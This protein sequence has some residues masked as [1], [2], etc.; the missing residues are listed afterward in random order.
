MSQSFQPTLLHNRS[1]IRATGKDAGKLLQ[2]LLTCNMEHLGKPGDVVYGFLLTPQGRF[3]HEML[4]VKT[5]DG[6][7]LDTYNGNNCAGPK[8][9][10][11]DEQAV[12]SQSGA[13]CARQQSSTEATNNLLKR[14]KIYTLK[15]DAAFTIDTE[16]A[17]LACTQKP[18]DASQHIT[19]T[20]PRHGELGYRIY[21][22]LAALEALT[23][24]SNSTPSY[25]EHRIALGIPLAEDFVP[26]KTL[27]LDYDMDALHG[28]DFEKGCYVGQEV[29]ARMHYR[30]IDKKGIYCIHQAD[31]ELTAHTPITTDDTE[32]G[33]VLSV[34]GARGIAMVRHEHIDA[35][36]TAAGKK[37]TLSRPAWINVKA[38]S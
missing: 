24:N 8:S 25:N 20:D 1:I 2:G 23:D 36:L 29:T 26:E 19:I 34:A 16:L 35:A 21:G 4:V 32:A 31:G 6:F 13:S 9:E 5:E 38:P 3:L 18:A 14:F 33:Q 10:S 17:T 27:L 15:S 7:L 28:V 37:I 12:S 30:G 11:A 22:E